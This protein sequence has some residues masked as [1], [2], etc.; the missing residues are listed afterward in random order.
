[1]QWARELITETIMHAGFA[2]ILV[3]IIALLEDINDF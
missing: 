1:M 3:D 2:V